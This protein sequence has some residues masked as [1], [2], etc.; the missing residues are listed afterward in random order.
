MRLARNAMKRN[1][2]TVNPEITV[3][4]LARTLMEEG[5]SGAPVV[6]SQ[7]FLVGVVS[8]TDLVRHDRE[9]LAGAEED[10]HP[11]Y[12]EID[13]S[14]P[15]GFHTESPDGTRVRD[16]MTPLV[17]SA[18]ETTPLRRL[19][20]MMLRKHVHRVIITRD[21]KVRGIITSMDLLRSFL[22]KN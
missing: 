14:L 8:Q 21:G 20:R 12:Q 6:D 15:R 10:G 19:A 5:I 7:G 13:S 1:V 22:R 17:I 2:V 18:S 16:I 9:G 3:Q 11:F 4:E